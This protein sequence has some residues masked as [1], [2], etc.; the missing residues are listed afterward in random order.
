MVPEHELVPE[1]APVMNDNEVSAS[2]NTLALQD[3]YGL[4]NPPTGMP[5]EKWI[6]EPDTEPDTEPRPLMLITV[7]VMVNGPEN[8]VPV[9]ATCHVIRPG[10]DASDAKPVHVPVRSTLVGVGW[11]GDPQAELATLQAI[12]STATMERS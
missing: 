9:W 2:P 12:A 8:D 5:I 4:S 7:S 6:V 1:Y 3:E 11:V 10:P